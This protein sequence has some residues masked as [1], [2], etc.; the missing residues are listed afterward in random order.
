VERWRVAVAIVTALAALPLLAIDNVSSAD[1]DSHHVASPEDPSIALLATR[2][3]VWADAHENQREENVDEALA[4]GQQV[5]AEEAA[6]AAQSA[7]D[8][9][10]AAAARRAAEAKRKADAAARASTRKSALPPAL[11]PVVLPPRR[12]DPTADQWAALRACEASGD[13]SAVSSQGRFRGAYQFD[14]ATWD[15][16]AREHFPE[17]VGVDPAAASPADQDAVALALYRIRGTSPWPRC[18]SSLR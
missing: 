7:A 17:L 6:R 8:A 5:Q 10:A 9:S 13:Y 14:Q 15:L 3:A 2:A 16:I 12:G 11:P 4:V 1:P 18:G